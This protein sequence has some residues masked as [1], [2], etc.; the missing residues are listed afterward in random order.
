MITVAIEHRDAMCSSCD[1]S[2]FGP[3]PVRVLRVTTG[4]EWNRV[5]GRL[6]LPCA[7]ALRESLGEFL[8]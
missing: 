4:R 1:A 2:N 6:C 5:V 8:R 3:D 7:R